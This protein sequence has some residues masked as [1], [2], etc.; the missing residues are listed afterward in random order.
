MYSKIRLGVRG[1]KEGRYFDSLLG[2]L[3]GESTSPILFSLFV[4]DL[5]GELA[6][7]AIGSRVMDIIIMLIKFAD[8]MAVFSETREGLQIALDKLSMYCKKWGVSVN[9]PKTKIVVFREGGRLGEDDRWTFDG[10]YLEVVSAFKYLGVWLGTTGSFSRCV[11]PSS[12][13]GGGDFERGGPNPL[14][15]VANVMRL[16]LVL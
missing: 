6:N 1:D 8:D 2:L 13:R 11:T 12:W 15:T 5:E 3:Q 10:I 14:H 7:D 9:I 4:N 16:R